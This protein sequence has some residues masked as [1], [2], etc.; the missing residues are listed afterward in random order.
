[1]DEYAIHLHRGLFFIRESTVPYGQI[2]NVQIDRPYHYRMFGIAHIEIITNAGQNSSESDKK[3]NFLIPT[4]DIKI[5]RLLSKHL[6]L[7]GSQSQDTNRRRRKLED[8]EDTEEELDENEVDDS[9][10]EDEESEE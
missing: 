7:K 5:A 10:E 1:M 8:D 4:I 9:E 6:L 3:K 2:S